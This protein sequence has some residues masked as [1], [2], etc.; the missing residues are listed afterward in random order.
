MFPLFTS[1]LLPH[2]RNPI[3]DPTDPPEGE[4][5]NRVHQLTL[6]P[7]PSIP[8]PMMNGDPT[9]LSNSL[10]AMLTV[11]KR[12]LPTFVEP[13]PPPG[14][15]P[16]PAL[17]AAAVFLTSVVERAVGLGSH[18]GTDMRGPFSVAE[19]KGLRIET[20]VRY[21]VWR[22]TP[23]EVGQAVGDLISDL[24]GDRD[25]LRTEGFLRVSLKSTGSSESVF[26][27]EAWRQNIEFD[28]LFE[29]P[30]RDSDGAQSLIARIPIAM[31][32][33]FNEKTVV[34]DQLAR[35][36]QEAAFPLAL[37]GPLSIG[38]LTVLAFIPGTSPSG[39]VTITRT[40]D[41]A[42]G[43][44]TAHTTLT[45]FVAAV[46][47]DNPSQQHAQVTFPSLAKFLAALASFTITDGALDRMKTDL[48]SDAVLAKLE[49][50]KD[51]EVGGEDEFV[52]L[53]DA[54]LTVAEL[55]AFQSTILKD[56]ATSTSM[57]LG[58]W[59]E[60]GIADKYD[61][62]QFRS[63]PPI[64]LTG[65]SDRFEITYLD[66]VFDELTIKF[67]QVAILYLRATRGLTT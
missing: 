33:E 61:S 51:Q 34:V 54:T 55:T 52:S 24:L 14:P 40:F 4:V 59:D 13:P 9:P 22:R 26:A 32:G 16:P 7:P 3:S 47:G 58:D 35:W 57:T 39:T 2:R 36:D 50:I 18:V 45:S 20:V 12:Y 31:K 65:V 21:E 28:V 37:R 49:A 62:V 27:E 6:V 15:P 42:T 5:R 17:P 67:D 38:A 19:L 56:A 8:V 46:G 23:A 11:L 30:Y 1:A 60:D 29:F 43:L 10:A 48:V 64:V 53:L 44:P 25:A 63:K 66:P 41:G